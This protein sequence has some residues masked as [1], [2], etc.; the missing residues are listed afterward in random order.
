[1]YWIEIKHRD[2]GLRVQ[3]FPHFGKPQA[4]SNLSETRS[5]TSCPQLLAPRAQGASSIAQSQIQQGFS[6][7]YFLQSSHPEKVGSLI[8]TAVG[9]SNAN[10]DLCGEDNIA[11]ETHQPK[12]ILK[13]DDPVPSTPNRPHD[14]R[15]HRSSNHRCTCQVARSTP[16]VVRALCTQ[17]VGAH[18]I[19]WN[20]ELF[21]SVRAT[22]A[23]H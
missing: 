6:R 7:G 14:S 15:S 4:G 12:T 1:M 11:F 21:G 20:L 2:V 9:I 5:C 8:H 18:S 13:K 23:T 10:H 17:V 3:E 22:V 19:H 16:A